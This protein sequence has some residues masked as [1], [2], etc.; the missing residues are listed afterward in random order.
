MNLTKEE[1]KLVAIAGLAKEVQRVTGWDYAAG[2]WKW[3]IETQ[4]LWRTTKGHKLPAKEIEYRATSWSWVSISTGVF[5]L[6]FDAAA[7]SPPLTPE[8]T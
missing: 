8:C 1:D 6:F 4:L 5:I 2:L 3:N 7:K